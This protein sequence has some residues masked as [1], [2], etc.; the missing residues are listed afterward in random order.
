MNKVCISFTGHRDLG[1]RTNEVAS[2][3]EETMRQL[4]LIHGYVVFICGGAMGVDTMASGIALRLRDEFKQLHPQCKV[5]VHLYLPFHDHDAKF[6][7]R[8]SQIVRLQ[9]IHADVVKY[10]HDGPFTHKGL[11]QDRNVA[12]VDDSHGTIA[13]WDGSPGGT[14]NC[15]R[16]AQRVNQHI[17]RYDYKTRQVSR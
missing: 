10:I 1:D 5:E 9:M 15:V 4:I 2:F 8:I 16:Y 7:S 17:Y 13:I 11:Y 14:G 6:P 12:M 3:L